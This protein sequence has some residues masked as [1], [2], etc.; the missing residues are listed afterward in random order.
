MATLRHMRIRVANADIAGSARS[1]SWDGRTPVPFLCEC[2]DDQCQAHVRVT[3]E[4]YEAL[5]ADYRFLL[6]PGHALDGGEPFRTPHF[7][8]GI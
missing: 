8:F 5:C 7:A 6:A 4:M 3:L 1:H 2:D